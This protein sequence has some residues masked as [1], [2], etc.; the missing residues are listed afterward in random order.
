MNKEITSNE[1]LSNIIAGIEKVK[2]KDIT[3]LDLREV[4][5][6]VCEYFVICNGNTNTQVAAIS[7]SVQK[8]VS[9]AEGHQKPWHVEGEMNAEWVLIDYV[10]VVVH[11][12]QPQVRE[13]YDLEGLWGD[14]K[15][16]NVETQY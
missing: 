4:E 14:A 12:F 1:L 11:I 2:G 7:G 16:I 10:D 13:H 6:A 3:I 9:Q 8:V 5:S 15:F